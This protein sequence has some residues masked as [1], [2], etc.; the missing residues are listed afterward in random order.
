MF[1]VAERDYGLTQKL[2]HLE[3]GMGLSTI[4]Q[5]ARGET[6]M[7]GEAILKLASWS[8]FPSALLSILFEGT[9]RLI[10]DETDSDDDD[11]AALA[12]EGAGM[13]SDYMDAAADGKITP[14]EKAR[15]VQ[16]ATRMTHKARR[17]A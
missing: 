10:T 2:I 17:I 5:Y 11:L 4:G 14:I 15:L 8:D 12:R 6:A 9:G 1:R 16:R 7:G 3:T 13:A